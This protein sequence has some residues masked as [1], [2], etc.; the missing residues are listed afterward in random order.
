[1]ASE[2]ETPS[3]GPAAG[4]ARG[5]SPLALLRR[6]Y[7]W[8][9]RWADTPYGTP[10][11]AA[12]A[13]VESSVF[14]IPPDVLLIALSAARPRRAFSYA[15]VATVASVIG[16]L[17]GY[18]LGSL[19]MDTVGSAIVSFYHLGGQFAWVQ[20]KYRETAF[21]A[22]FTAG[23]TPIPYKI[24]TLAAGAAKISLPV[25]LVASILGRGARFFGVAAL[26]YYFG[27]TTRAW[28]DRYFDRLAILF[29]LL[30]VAGFFLIRWFLP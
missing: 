17:L 3:A 21:W 20:A 14:P 30:L 16:G 2:P 12:L 19:F 18:L 27:P 23:L 25:F 7:D 1:M 6:L 13:F 5:R 10:A 4:A 28:I 24:F 15:A 26:L 11:L 9:L 29:V 8:T 22:I